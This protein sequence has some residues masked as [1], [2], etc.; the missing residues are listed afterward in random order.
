MSSRSAHR[1]AF[2]PFVLPD[3]PVACFP[4]HPFHPY[5]FHFAGFQPRVIYSSR[6][7]NH[8]RSRIFLQTIHALCGGKI[9][10]DIHAL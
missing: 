8:P 3:N 7:L 4:A 6:A 10:V 1:L 5:T 9:R 2:S